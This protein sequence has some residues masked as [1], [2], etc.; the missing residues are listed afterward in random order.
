[1]ENKRS[2]GKRA[3]KRRFHGNR[4]TSK[5]ACN[6][7]AFNSDILSIS[8][9][10]LTDSFMSSNEA[11]VDRNRINVSDELQEEC[12]TSERKIPDSASKRK[13]GS[14]CASDTDTDEK[15]FEG[16]I[17]MDKN[18]LF[19]FLKQ[20][21]SCKKCLEPV[22]LSYKNTWDLYSTISLTCDTCQSKHLL[23]NSRL[24]G[25]KKN[26]PELNR[27]IV[28]A[29]RCIGKGLEPLKTFCGIM[30]M[31][32]PV[33]QSAYDKICKHI[34]RASRD[35][36]V[37][38][39]KRG[40]SEEAIKS[41]SCDIT[42]SGD[43]TWKTRG[44][45]SQIGVCTVIGAETGKVIDVEVL[46]S[47]CKTCDLWK[48]KHSGNALE[49]WKAKHSPNC[50]KNHAGSSCKMEVDGMIKIFHRS[51]TERGVKYI[52]YIGDG[53]TKTFSSVVDSKPYGDMPIHK[54][55]CVGHVQKRMGARLRK[56][57]LEYKSKKLEDGRSLSGK[58]RLTDAIINKL[59][60]YYG[61]AIRQNADSLEN[62]RKAV[63]AVY[64]HTRSTDLEP[65]HSF[66]PSGLNSWC[67]YQQAVAKGTVN[68]F[69]H[70]VTLPAAVMDT[71]KPVFRDL[72]NPNL[73]S[74]CLGS[75]TQNPNEALNSLI[76][77]ICPKMSGSGKT[78]AEI[79]VHNAAILFNEGNKGRLS[80]MRLLGILPGMNCIKSMFCSDMKRV[81]SAQRIVLQNTV[82]ARR[83][84]KRL[85]IKLNMQQVEKEG[86]LYEPGAF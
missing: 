59:T 10:S 17:I 11:V 54:L 64:F 18:L 24:I 47:S 40:A 84:R 50:L 86:I 6:A 37:E 7:A 42:V 55:E 5:R 31:D 38:S 8:N 33:Y 70:K 48:D 69:R 32:T 14:Y 85:K 56:L 29:M 80:V 74:R 43:G 46:S 1:M 28:Y 3:K 83:A 53:D 62:M 68:K 66:C 36:A 12:L 23:K 45:T 44:Y 19:E 63:W 26:V 41:N 21:V 73:L 25:K 34:N 82:E 16:Y 72:S 27:R 51:Q 77:Q 78:I 52:N 71:L 2:S 75:H 35:A 15:R 61:N 20:N 9:N 30:D 49:E 79:A 67:K 76:W 81:K 4:F 58:G 39:M 13:I 65:L 22:D 57:K 60:V